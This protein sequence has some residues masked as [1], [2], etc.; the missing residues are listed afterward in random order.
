ME[1]TKGWGTQPGEWDQ[2]EREQQPAKKKRKSKELIIEG[3]MQ[4][5]V[6]QEQLLTGWSEKSHSD[7]LPRKSWFVPPV[8]MGIS[9]GGR[10]DGSVFTR[11]RGIRE[12]ENQR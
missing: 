10:W 12:S 2:E 4:G 11:H 1:W 3:G 5:Y 6:Q 9:D 7:G 8:L